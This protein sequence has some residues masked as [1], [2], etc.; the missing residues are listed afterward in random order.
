MSRISEMAVDETSNTGRAEKAFSLALGP[1]MRRQLEILSEI[2]GFSSTGQTIRWILDQWFESPR[3]LSA[4]ER[5]R[6]DEE[7][8]S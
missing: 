8:A 6:L 7:L 3:G 4:K 5:A 2:R 1:M